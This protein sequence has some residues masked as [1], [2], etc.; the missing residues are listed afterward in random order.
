MKAILRFLALA[1][2]VSPAWAVTYKTYSA[3][4]DSDVV[5]V[6]GPAHIHASGSFGSGT[7]TCYFLAATGSYKALSGGAFTAA[8]DVIFEFPT[9]PL[10]SLK[11]TLA[12]STNPTLYLEIRSQ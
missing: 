5:P 8:A 7:L 6:R 10:T 4:G 3:D 1:L 2:L 12:G 11:C 9:S